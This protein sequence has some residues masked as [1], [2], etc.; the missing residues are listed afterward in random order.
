MIWQGLDTTSSVIQSVLM[1]LGCHPEAQKKMQEEIDDVFESEEK[2]SL[3]SSDLKKLEC[4][5]MVIKE[6]MRLHPA[7]PLF[8]RYLDSPLK[9]GTRLFC[10]YI[11]T[12]K[13]S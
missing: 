6:V 1:R 3:N 13:I 4:T 8:Q 5:E 7:I 10:V 11:L 2:E 12:S 9:L